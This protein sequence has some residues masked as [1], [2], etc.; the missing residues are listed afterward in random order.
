MKDF[1]AVSENLFGWARNINVGIG[2]WTACMLSPGP[3]RQ[4]FFFLNNVLK[5]TNPVFVTFL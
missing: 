4:I 3:P 1:R 5:K 2:D